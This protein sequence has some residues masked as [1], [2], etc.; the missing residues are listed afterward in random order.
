MIEEPSEISRY[1]IYVYGLQF[2]LPVHKNTKL[3]YLEI[4]FT[5]L[6]IWN[7]LALFLENCDNSQN[8]LFAYTSAI[9]LVPQSVPC[10]MS[11]IYLIS[12]ILRTI[13][14]YRLP[15]SSLV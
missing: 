14:R 13:Q 15:E 4:Y 12:F 1:R 7:E 11:A 5:S 3:E 6:D 2:V 8:H 10:K 9:L